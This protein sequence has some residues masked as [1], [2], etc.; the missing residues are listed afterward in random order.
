MLEVAKAS[1]KTLALGGLV[2]LGKNQNSN[3]IT[4]GVASSKLQNK[5]LPV[6]RDAKCGVFWSFSKLCNAQRNHDIPF[7]ISLG[8]M[9][10]A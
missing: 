8:H 6:S 4:I 2:D 5:P 10:E 9:L 7:R 1:I 3:W